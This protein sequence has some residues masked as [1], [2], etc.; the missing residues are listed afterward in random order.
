M[1][2]FLARVQAE[3]LYS[4]YRGHLANFALLLHGGSA[5][6]VGTSPAYT[7]SLGY[8]N[9]LP[10]RDRYR[11]VSADDDTIA[12]LHGDRHLDAPTRSQRNVHIDGHRASYGYPYG[13]GHGHAGPIQHGHQHPDQYAYIDTQPNSY[14]Y[15]YI[16]P[17]TNP[18]PDSHLDTDLYA[19]ADSEPNPDQHT[20]AIP[21]ADRHPD[22]DRGFLGAS[23]TGVKGHLPR[24]WEHLDADHKRGHCVRR[25]RSLPPLSEEQQLI[26][27]LVLII[28]LAI[29][30]LYC[31][32]FASVA[33]HRAWE[34]APLPWEAA[35]P[36]TETLEAPPNP[37]LE[38]PGNGSALP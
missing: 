2:P 21:D 7:L 6:G 14:A 32:G 35:S 12:Y 16:H 33:L 28:L 18:H 25:K 1:V 9:T 8:H 27:G 34:N 15:A 4:V 29:S 3:D 22:Y 10:A 36:T 17:N 5:P 23:T 38:A 26:L 24:V 11:H 13:H 31:L 19:D 37:T 30:M 20:D